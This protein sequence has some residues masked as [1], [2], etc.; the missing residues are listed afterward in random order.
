MTISE[1]HTTTGTVLNPDFYE[2]VFNEIDDMIYIISLEGRILSTNKALRTRLGL[3]SEQIAGR[4][5]LIFHPAEQHGDISEL[6]RWLTEDGEQRKELLLTTASG[7]NVHADCRFFKGSFKGIASVFAIC[8]DLTDQR[9]HKTE[10]LNSKDQLAAILDNMPYYAWMKDEMGRYI[11]VNKSFETLAGKASEE[12]IGNTDFELWPTSLARK[13]TE[14]DRYVMRN[15]RQLSIE[16]FS[17]RDGNLEWVETL[18]T[19]V[20]DA[21]GKTVGTTGIARIITEQRNLQQELSAQKRFLKAM[22]DAIPDLIFYKDIDSVYLGC[23]TAFAQKFIGL[24]EEEIIGRTDMDFVKDKELAAFFRQKDREMMQR[25]VPT[26]NEEQ[27]TLV[28]GSVIDIE[29]M[30]TPLYDEEGRVSGLIGVSRDITVRKQTE[31]E[32]ISAQQSAEA[33]NIMKSQF[34]ANMSHEIRT[35]MNGILGFLDILNRTEL[36]PNQKSYLTEAR[37]ASEILL[38]LINDIL[39]FSKI[40]AGHM[41]LESR[42]FILR[43]VVESAVALTVP[44]TDEGPRMEVALSENLPE[45]VIGDPS[46]LKQILTN[47]PRNRVKFLEQGTILLAAERANVEEEDIVLHFSVS[48]TGVG[49]KK[50]DQSLLFK[51]FTQADASTS[52]KHGGSGL[53]LSITKELSRLM[54]GDVWVDSTYGIGST[55]H[56]VL[57]F[58]PVAERKQEVKPKSHPKAADINR[59][60]ATASAPRILLAEDNPINIRLIAILLEDRG[61][62]WDIATD[63]MEAV[64]NFRRNEYDLILMDCQMPRMDGYEASRIIR[65]E[66]AGRN[67]PVIIAM[68]ANA[69][70]GDREKCLNAGMDDYISKPLSRDSFYGMLDKY[71][72]EPDEAEQLTLDIPE[73]FTEKTSSFENAVRSI[74]EATGVDREDAA[75]LLKSYIK[76]LPEL[77]DELGLALSLG[78][79]EAMGRVLHKLIGTSE[80]LRLEP[81]HSLVSALEEEHF[82]GEPDPMAYTFRLLKREVLM[83]MYEER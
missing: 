32:L 67:R 50:E 76:K 61:L 30:K 35:P 11:A 75:L 9:L 73:I 68:T 7:E 74:V 37:N 64:E 14:D 13:Y 27:I 31:R 15:G 24:S 72:P 42:Q 81:L 49:I 71:L 16:E 38:Y 46:R 43:E 4:D 79:Q 62:T 78:D 60:G 3:S 39:D 82:K 53:G 48:D 41:I 40:E 47:L 1:N 63:G 28:D 10:A 51:P 58:Q 18:K 17:I 57:R 5:V 20:V 8:K 29:T 80:N 77:I 66:E 6:L 12:I 23:N 25:G 26:T 21:V 34:L 44:K 69:M 36:T 55:F 33:A 22:I 2:T 70:V 54:G 19:P 56:V 45:T 59:T 65:R 83:L 52:R